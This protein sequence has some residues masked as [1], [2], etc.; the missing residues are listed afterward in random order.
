MN[1]V[2]GRFGVRKTVLVG[3]ICLFLSAIFGSLA[4]D[5]TSLVLSQ[6]VFHGK[7]DQLDVT[8]T[9]L[10]SALDF[11]AVFVCKGICI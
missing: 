9:L 11:I 10:K 6:A 7:F 5:V 3:G 4:R 8:K 2:V 1:A